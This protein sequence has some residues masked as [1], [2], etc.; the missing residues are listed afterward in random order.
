MGMGQNETTRTSVIRRLPQTG[1]DPILTHTRMSPCKRETREIG[2]GCVVVVF[3]FC[4]RRG[5]IWVRFVHFS[6]PPSSTPWFFSVWLPLEAT[7]RTGLRETDNSRGVM[8]SAKFRF[9]YSGYVPGGSS[10][11]PPPTHPSPPPC[12]APVSG[13]E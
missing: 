12:R 8:S 11:G 5:K 7:L 4:S 6:R 13:E 1:G 3:L 10:K 2:F 9:G